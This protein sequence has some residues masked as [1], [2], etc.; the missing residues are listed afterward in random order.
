M[1]VTRGMLIEYGLG[2]P[3]LV[4]AFEF[5]PETLSRTRT[6]KVQAG[7]ASGTQGGYSFL[8]PTETSRASQ[9][10]TME[11]E[12]F[13]IKV[14]LDAT[15]RMG[16]GDAIASEVGVQP[17]IDTLRTMV[18]PKSQGPGGLQLLSS[19]GLGGQRAF[20]R[21]ESASV[22]LFLWGHYLLPIFLTS[23]AVQE[24]AHM[25]TLYPYRAK[26]DLTMQVI[27]SRNPFYEV[28]KLRQ[29]VS[30]A[31]NT[32]GSLSGSVSFSFGVPI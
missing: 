30:A 6:I 20:Q 18:E 24:L 21:N 31:R 28:E 25:P 26:V 23:V 15:D 13:T 3:P 17:E 1:K 19:L 9:G 27:E 12:T 16:E 8:L 7:G 10:V 29:V 22:L 32:V 2:L 14:L 11:P 5:N 4:L